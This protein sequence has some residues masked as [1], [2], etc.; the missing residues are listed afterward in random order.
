MF[1]NTHIYTFND[2]NMEKG[3]QIR[4]RGREYRQTKC[5]QKLFW[6]F[7]SISCRS[8]WR[9]WKAQGSLYPAWM[10]TEGARK[11][12]GWV[13][14][15]GKPDPCNLFVH[16]VNGVPAGHQIAELQ[17]GAIGAGVRLPAG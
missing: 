8:L 6:I 15:E 1:G 13:L 10:G 2:T 9:A 12:L 7:M 11:S 17:Q 14:G 4:I 16:P 3:A 5:F